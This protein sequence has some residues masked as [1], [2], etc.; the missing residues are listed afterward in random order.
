MNQVDGISD[1]VSPLHGSVW[2]GLRKGKCCC[3]ASGVVSG[4]KLSLALA[5]MPDTLVSSRVPVGPFK[6]L[7]RCWSPEGVSEST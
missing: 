4:R 6:L 3:L 1:V 2:E 7:S 5:L